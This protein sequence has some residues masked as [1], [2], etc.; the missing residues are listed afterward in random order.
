MMQ[1]DHKKLKTQ[2][3]ENTLNPMWKKNFT[4]PIELDSFQLEPIQVSIYDYDSVGTNDKIGYVELDISECVTKN[5]TW[6]IN[7]IYDVGAPS[8]AKAKKEPKKK[9]GQVYLQVKFLKE[10]DQDDGVQPEEKE[11]LAKTLAAMRRDGTFFKLKSR[12]S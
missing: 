9:W 5:N 6:A 2:T 3:I 1:P 4:H 11:D 12:I 10:G 7:N 8:P